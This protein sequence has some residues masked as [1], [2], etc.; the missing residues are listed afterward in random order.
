MPLRKPPLLTLNRALRTYLAPLLD[1]SP[2]FLLIRQSAKRQWKLLA[3]TMGTGLLGSL[4]EGATLG[5]IFLAVGLMSGTSGESLV[6]LPIL[7]RVPW[8]EQWLQSF[9]HWSAPMLFMLL[10]MLAVGLQVL[11]SLCTYMNGVATG[12]FSAR[13]NREVT[14]LLNHRILSITYACAG[15]YRVGDLLNYARTGGDTVMR[16]ITLANNLLVTVLQLVV[17]L[18][19]LLAISPLLLIV[20]AFLAVSLWYVQSKLLPRMRSNAH[21]A[22][23][24]RVDLDVRITENIQ[25][26][27]LLH[28]MGG[29]QE[30]VE[31]FRELLIDNE[32][33]GRR[34]AR[35]DNVISPFS[36]LLP[37]LA[38]AVIAVISVFTFTSRQ[39]GV[40]PSLVT[41][42]LALQR[43][44]VRLGGLASLGNNYANS[45]AEVARLNS[46]LDDGDKKFVR[47]GGLFVDTLKSGIE[48]RRVA[49][50]YAADLPEALTG[51]NL[52]IDRGS[53][54]ALVGPSGAGKSSIADLL[55]GLY[56]PTDGNVEID[57]I[58]LR[59]LD[60]ASW[61]EQLGVVSQD[62]FLFNASIANNI[63]YGS[64]RANQRDIE[65]AAA[66]AQADGFIE[67]LPEGY[68]TPVGERGY[69]LSGGQRQRLSLARALLRN[70]ELLIL[71]EAT[72]A[73]DSQSERLVQ[74][75]IERFERNHTVLVIAHRLSTIVNAD[76]ICVMEQGRILE[77]GN[78]QELLKRNGRYTSLW[79]QQIQQRN[80]VGNA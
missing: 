80:S 64:P 59:Q 31:S 3:V 76:L 61:Q 12:Y 78:H 46:I 73:L 10:L 50:R 19:I 28:S 24:V 21:K 20:A 1:H 18:A 60:L 42:V 37:I 30:A 67:A 11:M 58:D 75:A 71:D 53:T 74:E 26:L 6:K 36:A 72:S 44:N 62:T 34:S 15:S 49:L 5:V 77:R 4:S 56:D 48:L 33:L 35:L 16:Q 29:L 23:Q 13:L 41:F 47:T 55:V 70:P 54:V 22:Q 63:A 38:I 45:A 7:Q 40:L 68:N 9:A 65:E 25:G 57:G 14:D 79:R 39:S 43:F 66:M 52:R 51:I 27:R 8:L 2:A 32:R 69:R 17:Y